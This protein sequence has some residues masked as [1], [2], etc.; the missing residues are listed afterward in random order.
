M[1][2]SLAVGAKQ[3]MPHPKPC[4]AEDD[5]TLCLLQMYLSPHQLR[6]CKGQLPQIHLR[7]YYTAN[8]PEVV[9]GRICARSVDRA[10]IHSMF[11][12]APS[13]S[14]HKC[15]GMKLR[16]GSGGARGWLSLY[17]HAPVW[18]SMGPKRFKFETV[19]PGHKVCLSSRGTNHTRY[20]P[21]F[22]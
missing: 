19:L 7:V 17:C 1:S 8:M 3:E 16:V 22:I 9:K 15:G 13:F 11:S 6:A 21:Y 14:L 20:K 12:S 10:L 4:D 5:P 18:N 2:S